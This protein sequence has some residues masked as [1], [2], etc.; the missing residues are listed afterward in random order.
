MRSTLGIVCVL[1][2]CLTRSASAAAPNNPCA[3]LTPAQVSGVVGITVPAGQPI[4]TTGCSWS[5]TGIMTTLVLHDG[6]AF[7]TMKTPLPNITRTPV[8][9][10]GDD[11]FYSTVGT[12]T[13]LTVKKGAVAFVVRLY[14]VKDMNTQTAMEKSLA[15]DVLANL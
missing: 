14:G 6:A 5:A 1:T 10:L 3:L 7:A 15:L 13:T 9:G 4:S 8:T 11:A 2:A 12:L